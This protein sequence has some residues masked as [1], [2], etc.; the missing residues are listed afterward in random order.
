[1]ALQWLVVATCTVIVH[2]IVFTQSARVVNTF[3]NPRYNTDFR[4]LVLNEQT[5][6]IYVGAIN[7]IYEL[8]SKLKSVRSAVKTGPKLDNPNCQ[9]LDGSQCYC[10]N[11]VKDNCEKIETD[12]V[13]QALALD[14]HGN[15]L[16]A[17]SNLFYGSC[18]HI[19]LSDFKEE[20]HEP[21]PL[22]SN[23]PSMVDSS[24]VVMV[25][26]GLDTDNGN[27]YVATTKSSI[28]YPEFTDLI[29]LIASRNLSNFELAH[30][31]FQSGTSIKSRHQYKDI[32]KVYYR[33]GFSYAG[34]TYFLAV[35][36]SW[37]ASPGEDVPYESRIMRV[38][39][40]DP[41]FHSYVE[42]P[43]KCE[44]DG[45]KDFRIV[46]AAYIARP[47][48]QLV[49]ALDLDQD[50]EA[51]FVVFT[52]SELYSHR[53]K[54]PTA[55]CAYSLK[56]LAHSFKQNQQDCFQGNGETGPSH[57]TLPIRCQA[58]VSNYFLLLHT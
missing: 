37:A 34:F 20:Q 33:Y 29:P 46:Q 41:K 16:Y 52:S 8:D 47:G 25:A 57:I 44:P 39:Q 56:K 50:E 54:G 23:D 55:I 45:N 38:C 9:P 51:L 10:L 12:S 31:K 3:N 35:Q 14:I 48:S 7:R 13:S 4:H 27:L 17:C 24:V 22:V 11:E 32:F 53:P 49:D 26:P 5:G 36:K 6:Y 2:F 40:K 30:I 21:K 15:M 43:L 19:R 42:V 28:G 58:T 18:S 1:M